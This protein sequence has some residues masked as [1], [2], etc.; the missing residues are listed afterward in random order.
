MAA[1]TLPDDCFDDALEA[2]AGTFADETPL[3]VTEALQRALL[4]AAPSIRGQ[5]RAQVRALA[6]AVRKSCA[7]QPCKDFIADLIGGKQERSDEKKAP[8]P[9]PYDGPEGRARLT[10]NLCTEEPS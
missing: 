7:C 2:F 1:D 4:A 5:E 6:L 8:R 9:W 10:G 3:T